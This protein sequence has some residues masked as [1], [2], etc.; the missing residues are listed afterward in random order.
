MKRLTFNEM[1]GDFITAAHTQVWCS[2]ATLDT[3]NRLRSRV[4]HPIWEYNE[5]EIIGWVTTGRHSL[6]A[7]HLAHNPTLSLCY[8]KDPLKPLYVDCYGEWVDDQSEKQRIF[9]LFVQTPPPL[10]YNPADFLWTVDNHAS[11]LLKLKPWRIEL[12]DLFG[13]ARV[14]MI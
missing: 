5:R 12:A 2:V 1:V 14:W 13:E 8:M 10:G 6:K 11:G 9:D 4:L 3:Q 7:K